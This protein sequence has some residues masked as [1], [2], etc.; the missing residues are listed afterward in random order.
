MARATITVTN[1]F[2]Q[3][4]TGAV[5][6]TVLNQGKGSVIFNETASD[7]NANVV[8]GVAG[9]QFAQTEALATFVRTTGPTGVLR[10]LVDG[11]L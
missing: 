9:D 1:V 6:I 5:T 3:I 11:A 8:T 2:Q 4:A 10:L 7:T